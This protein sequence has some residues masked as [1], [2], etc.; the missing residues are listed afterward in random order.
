[1]SC[2]ALV[3]DHA[4]LDIADIR[5]A[6]GGRRKLK[7]VDRVTLHLDRADVEVE[8]TRNRANL[9]DGFVTYMIC[10]C[11]RRRA[12]VLRLLPDGHGAVCGVCVRRA[13][14]RYA[15]QVDYV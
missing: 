10:P 4:R 2:G 6:V 7:L 8:L 12:S 14:A 5:K 1:M 13:G 15:S 3:E 11:C 9:G